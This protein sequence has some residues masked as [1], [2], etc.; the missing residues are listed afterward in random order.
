MFRLLEFTKFNI[1]EQC[2][3]MEM[4]YP[5]FEMTLGRHHCARKD[6]GFRVKSSWEKSKLIGCSQYPF[7]FIQW[8]GPIQP[9]PLS[10]IYQVRIHYLLDASLPLIRVMSPGLDDARGVIPHRYI[11]GNLCLYFWKTGFIHEWMPHMPIAYTILPWATHWLYH[12]ENWLIT[13]GWQGG[14]IHPPVE[15]SNPE[16]EDPEERQSALLLRGKIRKLKK[17]IARKKRKL[18]KAKQL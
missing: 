16:Q 10:A 3:L 2:S 12:Y 9:T 14:G 7:D 4:I 11:S 1:P 6:K 15:Q 5:E 13:G 18:A 8:D 17:Q